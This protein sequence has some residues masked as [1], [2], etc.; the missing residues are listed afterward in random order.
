MGSASRDT[1]PAELIRMGFPGLSDRTSNAYLIEGSRSEYHLIDCGSDTDANWARLESALAR[2]GANIA[3]VG[4]VTV[5]HGHFDHSGMA[6]RISRAS[7]AV[8]RAHE[9]DLELM[10][11]GR[12][13]GGKD[14]ERLLRG[15]G[16]PSDRFAELVSVTA[17]RI[18]QRPPA[19]ILPV[20]DGEDLRISGR[21]LIALATPGHTPGHICVID[22]ENSVA[23]VGD[24]VLPE[25]N[26]GVGLGGI[27]ERN[28]MVDY[29]RAL[30]AL[31]AEKVGLGLPGHGSSIA[32]L[33]ERTEM[34]RAHHLRRGR[35]VAA[36][37]NTTASVWDVAQ[38]VRWSRGWAALRGV[39][40]FSAL[41][42]VAQHLARNSGNPDVYNAMHSI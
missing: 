42:Q 26:P 24:H 33:S 13:Y 32:N 36:A 1:F 41:H 2:R 31:D 4:S 30:N 11:T 14:P 38:R 29:L 28:P 37:T 23:F 9:G 6:A 8:I 7:G 27:S 20:G 34:I 18:T 39:H 19:D 17:S 21:T 15:W 22:R 16:V 35:E 12:S 40:L 5:T 10:T 25:A 3:N